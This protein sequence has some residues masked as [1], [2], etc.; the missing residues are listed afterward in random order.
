MFPLYTVVPA[1]TV[2]HGLPV[3]VTIAV[4]VT[5]LVAIGMAILALHRNARLTGLRVAI[6]AASALAILVGALLVG[7]S[8]TRP[9]AAAASD[10]DR[11][12]RPVPTVPAETELSG[13]Q[14]PTL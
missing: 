2:S 4:A 7:G 12:V 10:E 14:L 11:G 8:L 13:F 5:A 6:G 1:T 9:P 3:A